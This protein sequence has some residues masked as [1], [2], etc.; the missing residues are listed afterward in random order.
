MAYG[1]YLHIPFC[2]SACSY[3]DFF[4]VIGREDAIPEF[5]EALGREI[6]LRADRAIEADTL[7]F[8]GGTPSLLDPDALA[9]ILEKIRQSF[10]V[11][12]DVEITCE[13]NPETVN[14]DKLAAYRCAGINRLSLGVQS[15]RD[16]DLRLMRRAHDA[17]RAIQAVRDARTAGF[18]N[19]S[20]D[21]ISALP[22][23]NL[24]DWLSN[25][26]HALSL[27]PDH[28]SAYALEYHPGTVF[29]LERDSGRL[30]PARELIERE[31]FLAAIEF[32]QARG[33]EHY[34]ISN[35]ARPGFA[36]RH[37]LKYWRHE[38]YLGFG[39]SA[40][41]FTGRQRSWNHRSL[42]RY[43][44]DLSSGRMPFAGQE[45]LT[46]AQLDLER[47]LLG[48]RTREGAE[49]LGGPL[50]PGV[51]DRL[52]ARRGR[53]LSLTSEGLVLY[54]SVCEAFAQALP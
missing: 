27:G 25:V 20:F 9:R 42:Q 29:T 21:L 51:P 26:Q 32:L 30:E 19:L 23:M 4:K 45:D 8:G 39:P 34:E 33:Y 53:N 12:R 5:L 38:P 6:D 44:A 13:A 10:T 31:M 18:S 28:L 49:W 43:I 14:L 35:F 17:R 54:E 2:A 11:S 41:S 52:V 48:L 46:P 15:F 50:P 24:R 7:Y 47:L 37:N 40:H 1:L 22:G 16:G 36:S 3:C